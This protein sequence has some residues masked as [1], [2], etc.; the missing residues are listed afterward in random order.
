MTAK[1]CKGQRAET[2]E[3]AKGICGGI[4]S[5]CACPSEDGR[6]GAA[7]SRTQ[8]EN[9]ARNSGSGASISICRSC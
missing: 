4:P 6:A 9:N 2:G 1:A 5:P 8:G 3:A 7:G